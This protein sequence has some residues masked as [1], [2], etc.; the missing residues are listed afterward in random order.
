MA[1]IDEYQQDDGIG[2]YSFENLPQA[3]RV[4]SLLNKFYKVFKGDLMVDE[5]SG[6]REFSIEYFIISIYLLLRHID[7][8]YVFDKK[9]ENLL[10]EF[11]ISFHGRWKSERNKLIRIFCIFLRAGR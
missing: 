5:S 6:M 11:V 3:K 1:Y 7:A 2:N 4:L 9:E 10:H 8:H